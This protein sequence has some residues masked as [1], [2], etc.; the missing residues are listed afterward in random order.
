MSEEEEPHNPKYVTMVQCNEHQTTFK[1]ELQTIRMA[2][3]GNDMRGGIVKDMGDLKA[4]LGIF[5]TVLLPIAISVASAIL[6]A[7][8]INGFKIG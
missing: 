4:K 7:W 8:S 2:L 6:V 1:D 3:I 5:K